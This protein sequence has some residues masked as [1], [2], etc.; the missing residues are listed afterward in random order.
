MGFGMLGNPEFGYLE[1]VT[2]E[3]VPQTF[4]TVAPLVEGSGELASPHDRQASV[5][6]V[7]HLLRSRGMNYHPPFL[8]RHGYLVRIP[9]WRT[10][11]TAF[12]AILAHGAIVMD[13]ERTAARIHAVTSQ[14]RCL[15]AW[16]QGGVTACLLTTPL[17]AGAR[18]A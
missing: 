3:E 15:A 5:R 2:W 4:A 12:P 1:F 7:R 11:Q 9:V 14:H 6:H 16:A 13:A 18:S 8:G 17:Y 10:C